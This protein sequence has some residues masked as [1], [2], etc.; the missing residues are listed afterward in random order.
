VSGADGQRSCGRLLG[1]L[2]RWSVR[3]GESIVAHVS[4]EGGGTYD[5]QL[6]RVIQGDV[7]PDGPGFREELIPVDLGGPF[8]ARFQS[9]ETGSYAVVD[10]CGR[11]TELSSFGMS[12]AI[13]PTT[14]ARGTQTLVA[15]R[16]AVSG[17]GIELV[18]DDEGVLAA[19]L[20]SAEGQVHVRSDAVLIARRWYRICLSYD[21]DAGRLILIQQPELSYPLVDDAAHVVVDAPRGLRQNEVR[22]PLTFAARAHSRHTER[23]HFNGRIDN[24]VLAR[25][26]LSYPTT[27]ASCAAH[28]IVAAWDFGIDIPSQR[29]VDTSGNGLHGWLLNLPTRG[30]SGIGW[31]GECHTWPHDATGYSAIHFHDDDLYDAGW[32][33]SFRANI[34]G[35]LGSGVYALRLFTDEDEFYLPFCVRKAAA[36]HCANVVFLLPTASYMAYANNRIGLD[37]PETELVCGRLVELHAGDLFMQTH[38]ELGLSFYDLHS[39]GSGVYYSSRLRPVMDMQPKWVGKLGGKGSNV[40]QF[41]ADTHILGWLETQSLDYDVVTDEDLHHEGV[42]SLAGCRVLVTGSHPEY[43]SKDMRDALDD[44]VASGGRLMY[45]GGNGFYWRVSFHSQLPGVIECRKSEDGIRAVAPGPGEYYASFTGEYTGLWRRNGRPPNLLTGVGMVAQ[46]FDVSSPYI[47]TEASQDPR[48]AFVFEG[49]KGEVIGDFGLSG[50]AAAGIELDAADV[51]LG[52]PPHALV[53][54]SSHTHTDLYLM[55]PEDMLDPAPG[56]GGSE[57]QTIRADLVFFEAPGGGAVFSTGSIAWAGAMAWNAYDNDVA[58]ITENVLQRFVQ[59][60]PFN[61]EDPEETRNSTP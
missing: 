2:D 57:A 23:Q 13:W 37:V 54:A 28:E 35:D 52:T 27:A 31:N 1:Y 22:A 19:T 29:I 30:V 51:E 9:I 5:A 47:R 41:N 4:C 60:R 56:L 61:C 40:W 32:N 11:F 3:P 26:P 55:T 33:E 21:A 45:L 36:A 50:G 12:F 44:F 38:P 7:H 42:D 43:Y 24:P 25:V 58:R 17:Y 59:K 53:L 49:I 16:D 10:D 18:I 20:S 14:P 39:D 15:R 34:P 46:G 48:V 6:V 8:A